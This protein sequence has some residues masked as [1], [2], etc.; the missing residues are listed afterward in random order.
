MCAWNWKNI[1]H[2]RFMLNKIKPSKMTIDIN[3]IYIIV[4]TINKDLGRAPTTSGNTK[5]RGV[6]TTQ[7][8]IEKGNG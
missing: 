4:I 3:E 2:I 6:L 1:K 8:E 5:P 7:L